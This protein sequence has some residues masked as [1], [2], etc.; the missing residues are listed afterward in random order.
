[1]MFFNYLKV[2]GCAKLDSYKTFVFFFS[3]FLNTYFPIQVYVLLCESNRFR[4]LYVHL[5]ERFITNFLT[6]HVR[7]FF[8]DPPVLERHQ[9][10]THHEHG[11]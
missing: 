11:Q 7:A 4:E 3:I 1:M 9:L 8:Q 5:L 6:I 2:L 10:P